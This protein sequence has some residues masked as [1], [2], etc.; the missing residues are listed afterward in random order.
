[1]PADLLAEIEGASLAELRVLWTRTLGEPLPTC[2][3]RQ[4]L[5]LMLAWR[6]QAASDVRTANKT[7]R[8][9]EQL[10]GRSGTGPAS[11]SRTSP[12]MSRGTELIRDWKGAKHRVLVISDGYIYEG[13]RYAS[14]SVI[15]R[16][17]TGTRWS[18]PRFFG[19]KGATDP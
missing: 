11:K 6:T 14:L 4:F 2:G 5:R 17:I 15:A 16:R 9:L 8:R 13:E 7:L 10:A 12:S 19:V 18:G 1:M 3:N